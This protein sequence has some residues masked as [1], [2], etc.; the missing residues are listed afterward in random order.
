MIKTR[1]L[2]QESVFRYACLITALVNVLG[3]A[4]LALF[5]SPLFR[6]IGVSPFADP[7]AFLLGCALSFT[8][9]VAA[10]LV[11]LRPPEARGLL[12]IGALGKGL[13]A[14]ITYYFWATGSLHVFYMIFVMWDVAYVLIFF[15]YWLALA[16]P[17]LVELQQG[18]FEGL[19][20]TARAGA[21][22]ALLIGFSLTG[23]GSRALRRLAAGMEARGYTCDISMV[24][25]QEAIFTWP[26]SL[27]SFIRICARALVRA[28]ARIAPLE[29]PSP[30]PD[31]DLVVVQSPTWLLGMASPVEAVLSDAAY[32][33]VFRGRDAAVLVTCRGAYQ[34]T[35]A[36]IVRR[37][38]IAGANVVA[39]RGLQ[40][41]GREPRRLMSLWFYLIFR[42]AGVPKWL[43]SPTYGLSEETLREAEVLG[44]DLADRKRTR[45]HWTL[46]M[47]LPSRI[48]PGT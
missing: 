1:P 41:P 26:L 35:M 32:R 42:R 18:I 22:R 2:V 43:A 37:L 3:S 8:M 11:Y 9:G 30:R 28:E 45:K 23:T 12:A 31:W 19:E 7:H 24:V 44:G 38:E 15:L 47:Q 36:M 25:P 20:A 46:L 16:S 27:W 21:K 34:R 10:M 4:L 40:H 6:A 39:A 17:I 33:E 5:H 29:L 14:L 13:Y 48:A